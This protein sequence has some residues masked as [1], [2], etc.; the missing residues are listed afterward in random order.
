MPITSEQIIEQLEDLALNAKKEEVKLNAISQLRQVYNINNVADSK[1]L[2]V[3]VRDE[4]LGQTT[5]IDDNTEKE[6]NT[7]EPLIP[8]TR[9][10]WKLCKY[11][12]LQRGFKL[13]DIAFRL[14]ISKV[15]LY[16][17]LN[18]DKLISPSLALNICMILNV[19][20]RYMFSFD[21]Q[22]LTPQLDE[23]PTY[24]STNTE[25]AQDLFRFIVGQNNKLKE[26][27]PESYKKYP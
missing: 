20:P 25:E 8:G 21:T 11:V 5:V 12:I 27:L 17:G 4:L 6:E 15:S 26:K 3:I 23:L 22:N 10:H 13:Q 9:W 14:K 1:K 18:G 24:P 2:I 16:A 19:D 7:T